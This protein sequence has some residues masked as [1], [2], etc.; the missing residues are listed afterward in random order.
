[1]FAAAVPPIPVS[2]TPVVVVEVVDVCAL[3]APA[4]RRIERTA[5]LIIV[6]TDIYRLFIVGNRAL[7]R[8]LF[9]RKTPERKMKQLICS[10]CARV[11]RTYFLE[12]RFARLTAVRFLTRFASPCNSSAKECQFFLSSTAA[13]LSSRA[14]TFFARS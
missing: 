3:A 14:S 7:L 10:L 2:G 13:R 12:L 1:M 11:R 8:R 4:P 6:F 9:K 5:A